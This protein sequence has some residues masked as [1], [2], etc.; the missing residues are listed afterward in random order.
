MFNCLIHTY[1]QITL[2]FSLDAITQYSKKILV[3][4]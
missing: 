3:E 1:L 4:I 2:L